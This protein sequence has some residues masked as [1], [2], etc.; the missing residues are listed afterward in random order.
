MINANRMEYACK[1]SFN[2]CNEDKLIEMSE[3]GVKNTATTSDSI[4]RDQNTYEEPH[5][6]HTTGVQ[7]NCGTGLFEEYTQRQRHGYLKTTFSPL[8]LF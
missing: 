6:G 1:L 7:K 4:R 5:P 2:H 3:H 8:S